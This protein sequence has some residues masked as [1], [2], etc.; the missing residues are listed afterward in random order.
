[1]MPNKSW[2]IFV[3]CGENQDKFQAQ[4]SYLSFLEILW[5]SLSGLLASDLKIVL[6]YA[7]QMA[8]PR[9]KKAE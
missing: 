7:G 9:D 1:M 3:A 8:V 6:G 5:A 4:S 2:T